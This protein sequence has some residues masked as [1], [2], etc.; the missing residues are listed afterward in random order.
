MIALGLA[1]AAFALFVVGVFRD[2]RSFSN[3]VLLGLALAL[4]AFGAVEHLADEPGHRAHLLLLALLV[5]VALGPFLVAAFLVGNGVTVLRKERLRPANLLSLAAGL[6]IFAVL[7]GTMAA[8]RLGSFQVTLATGIAD[9]LFGYVSFLL[10]SYVIYAFIYGRLSTLFASADFV[11]VLGAGLKRDGRPTP[12]LAKRLNRGYEVFTALSRAGGD[13]GSG[14]ASARG[15]GGASARGDGGASARGDG[16]SSGRGDGGGPMIVVSGG[17]GS[18]ERISEADSMF[19]Y[20]TGLGVP[21]DRIMLEDLSRTTEENLRFSWQLIDHVWPDAP[22]A[23]EPRCV[24]V[25]SNFHVFRAAML[26]QRLGIRGQVT[27][28]PVAGYYWPSAM[29]R[30]FAAVFLGHK[31]VNFAVCALIVAVPLAYTAARNLL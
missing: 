14:G 11:I 15:D 23:A 17:K 30:E 1:V 6:V 12:L 4:A 3:S 22:D 24:I 27:G 16:G 26:A 28:A 8:V 2:P 31:L 10:V 5:V 13:S 18:D 29:L 19:T 25:T 7:G 21:P 9:L 20:L